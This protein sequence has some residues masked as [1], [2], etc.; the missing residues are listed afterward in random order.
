MDFQDCIKFANENL[1][2]YIATLEEDQPRVRAITLW[3]VDET[4]FY[5]QTQSY[6]DFAKQMEQNNK[7]EIC[8]HSSAG[9]GLGRMMRVS[10][11]VEPVTDMTLRKRCI[12]ERAVVKRMGIEKPEDPILAVFHLYTGEAHFFPFESG[13]TASEVEKIKF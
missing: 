7:I 11:K 2:C 12:E 4:G 13:R 3:Y 6:K 1:T 10:G 8:F 9:G 5:I